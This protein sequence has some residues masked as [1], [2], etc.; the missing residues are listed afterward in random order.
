[1]LQRSQKEPLWL[2]LAVKFKSQSNNDRFLKLE[3]V[4]LKTRK[5]KSAIY[6]EIAEGTFPAPVRVGKRAIAWRQSTIDAWM[7]A[8]DQAAMEG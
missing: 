3:E 1:M 4:K 2:S 7:E 5:S 8:I 6:R